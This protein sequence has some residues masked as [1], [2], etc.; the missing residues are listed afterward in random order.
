LSRSLAEV[1]E[2]L[3]THPFVTLNLSLLLLQLKEMKKVMAEVIGG[4]NL[5][6]LFPTIVKNVACKSVEL[7]KLVYQ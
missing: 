5:Q 7:K 1:N 3:L 2:H 6:D 4:E